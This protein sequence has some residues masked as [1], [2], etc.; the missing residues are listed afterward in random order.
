M[1]HFPSSVKLSKLNIGK[2]LRESKGFKCLKSFT[3]WECAPLV[4]FTNIQNVSFDFCVFDSIVQ[5]SAGVW[6]SPLCRQLHH[7]GSQAEGEEGEKCLGGGRRSTEEERGFRENCKSSRIE[8]DAGF[9]RI[10][11]GRR[12][13]NVEAVPWADNSWEQGERNPHPAHGNRTSKK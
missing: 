11:D 13:G 7:Q 8:S 5:I 10:A 2:V 4:I 9:R 12:R 3:L 1:K 6:G